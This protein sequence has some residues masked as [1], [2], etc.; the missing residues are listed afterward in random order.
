MPQL[1]MARKSRISKVELIGNAIDEKTCFDLRHA[2][3]ITGR[4][5][6]CFHRNSLG[7]LIN[8]RIERTRVTNIGQKNWMTMNAGIETD[9][10]Q[11]TL[12]TRDREQ[13]T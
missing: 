2:Y 8:N 1:Y 9:N 7:D 11:V 6:N 4:S 3:R 13:V 12:T 5:S 10:D